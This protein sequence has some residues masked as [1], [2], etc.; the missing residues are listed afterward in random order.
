M[1]D[2]NDLDRAFN[3]FQKK[4]KGQ[5]NISLS[6][7]S[8]MNQVIYLKFK[9]ILKENVYFNFIILLFQTIEPESLNYKKRKSD[10]NDSTESTDSTSK[11]KKPKGVSK[12]S[13]FM[14]K[15]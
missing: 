10:L 15:K 14:F 5:A 13:S 7:L 6:T 8:P 12:L 2:S 11:T 3:P 4:L 1:N 9:M